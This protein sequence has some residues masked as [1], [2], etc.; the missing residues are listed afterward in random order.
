VRQK[1]MF[2]DSATTTEMIPQ[3]TMTTVTTGNPDERIYLASD[4]EY[5]MIPVT[6]ASGHTVV[7]QVRFFSSRRPGSMLIF[8]KIGIGV[9]LKIQCYDLIFVK[10]DSILNKKKGSPNF[11]CR[12]IIKIITSVSGFAYF[13][14]RGSSFGLF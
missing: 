1:I 3:T 7:Q 14:S 10:P 2:P 5:A 11:F 9:F 13:C 6:D 8:G 12:N 4:L